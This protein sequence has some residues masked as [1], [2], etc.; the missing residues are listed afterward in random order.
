MDKDWVTTGTTKDTHNHPELLPPQEVL[1][2]RMA[3]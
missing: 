2:R 1:D 3:W